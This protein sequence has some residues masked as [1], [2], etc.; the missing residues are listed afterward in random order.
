MI[1]V[2]LFLL[3]AIYKT[4][5]TEKN[6]VGNSVHVMLHYK[7]CKCL[8]LMLAVDVV[9]LVVIDCWLEIDDGTVTELYPS[10]VDARQA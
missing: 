9:V 7:V 5:M 6:P 1:H 10:I 2:E 8:L 4:N 3:Y